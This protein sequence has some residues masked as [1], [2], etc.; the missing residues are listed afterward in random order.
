MAAL[1]RAPTLSRVL[2]VGASDRPRWLVPAIA[3]SVIG[4][5]L[6]AWVDFCTCSPDGWQSRALAVMLAVIAWGIELAG[7]RWPRWAFAL[8]TLL[9][10]AWLV[11]TRQAAAAPLFLILV[12]AWIAFTGRRT[13]AIATCCLALAALAPAW[14][15]PDRWVP[16]S[17]GLVFAGLGAY[18][19]R[20][21]HQLLS[22]LRLAQEDLACRERSAE[23]QRIAR[24]L[25]DVI[26][27]SLTVTLLHLKAARHVLERNP[28]QAADA[29][30]EAERLGRESLADV[31]RTVGL[32]GTTPHTD[33]PLPRASDIDTLVD[34][35]RRAGLDVTSSVSGSLDSIPPAAGLTLYRIAQE[36]LANAAR[37][38]P[39]APVRFD[40]S[41][42]DVIRLRVH[43]TLARPATPTVQGSGRGLLGMRERAELTGGTFR[44]GP[45]DAGWVVEVCLP[46]AASVGAAA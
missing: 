4:V 13:E 40:L 6:L 12:A 3:L 25:H 46:P 7:F 23:R 19:L 11:S 21:Q 28:R 5:A 17:V 24:E 34:E 35:Y 20:V 9:P 2:A 14:H 8:L 27:H 43:N 42:A 18:A 44:A 37:H 32:L 16:W 26:A 1:S 31:R 29:L 41:V 39:G 30:A 15:E 45:E 33:E 22:E 38:A 36:A 10:V